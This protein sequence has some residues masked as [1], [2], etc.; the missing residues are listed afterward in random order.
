MKI[1]YYLLDRSV[2]SFWG[3]MI[4]WH[5]L[6][7]KSIF[8]RSH[9]V[10]IT[11]NIMYITYMYKCMYCIVQPLES[12][13][14]VGKLPHVCVTTLCLTVLKEFDWMR[15]IWTLYDWFRND[16]IDFP[17]IWKWLY[18]TVLKNTCVWTCIHKNWFRKTYGI[19]YY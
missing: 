13:S 8:F 16:T 3:H 14:Y 12:F 15:F 2:Y 10:H 5:N 9:A 4:F 6:S 1:N 18:M 11:I 17:L 19:Y 7:V